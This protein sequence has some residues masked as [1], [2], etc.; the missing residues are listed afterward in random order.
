MHLMLE[1]MFYLW[2]GCAVYLK[3][4][5]S[6]EFKFKREKFKFQT[7]RKRASTINALEEDLFSDGFMM[8]CRTPSRS[9]MQER[10]PKQKN[11]PSVEDGQGAEDDSHG[12][13]VNQHRTPY[14][15]RQLSA[16][17]TRLCTV[18]FPTWSFWAGQ[19]CWLQLDGTCGCTSDHTQRFIQL[20]G[21]RLCNTLLPV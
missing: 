17:L 5:T 13:V 1:H 2:F 4:G 21:V 16:F 9:T 19:H 8:W 6:F 3:W 14:M 7:K 15:A 10:D 12:V 18:G 11:L 20:R